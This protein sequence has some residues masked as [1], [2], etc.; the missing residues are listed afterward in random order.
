MDLSNLTYFLAAAD[1][2]NFKKAADKLFI[3]PQALSKRIM[4]IEAY[5]HVTLFE[6]TRPVK[7]TPAGVQFYFYAQQLLSLLDETKGA[8]SRLEKDRQHII[9]MGLSR[10]R[11]QVYMPTILSVLREIDPEIRVELKDGYNREI[12]DLLLAGKIDLT[13]GPAMDDSPYIERIS[14]WQESLVLMLPNCIYESMSRY[15]QEHLVANG[16]LNWEVL[17][18]YPFIRMPEESWLGKLFREFCGDEELK[19]NV[20]F[21]SENI[22]TLISVC[23][24][25][26]G[27]FLCLDAFLLTNQPVLEEK[28]VRL[29][30]FYYRKINRICVNYLGE[31][32]LSE[33]SK[34]LIHNMSTLSDKFEEQLKHI[35]QLM[36][37]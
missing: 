28:G 5:F 35:T 32:Y 22:Q 3:S 16:R 31:Q 15:E 10:Y 2:L 8:M 18:N 4:A 11:S 24:A 36:K 33:A 14:G 23:A 25:G 12:R 26:F 17:R 21:E 34:V 20:I 19:L 30:P 37:G 27:M 6:R 29:L 7:L 9:S 13:I 1:T